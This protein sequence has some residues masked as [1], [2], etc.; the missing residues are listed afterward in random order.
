MEKRR[1]KEKAELR[2]SLAMAPDGG[3]RLRHSVGGWPVLGR[4]PGHLLYILLMTST[5]QLG[6]HGVFHLPCSGRSS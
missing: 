1:E 6:G 4:C 2:T 3:G 5:R